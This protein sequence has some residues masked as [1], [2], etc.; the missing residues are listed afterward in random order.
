MIRLGV[1][2]LLVPFLL[3]E[4]ITG[5]FAQQR[6]TLPQEI[7]IEL[8]TLY[9]KWR[10]TTVDS[11]LQREKA[12][13]LSDA[14]MGYVV[15]DFNGDRQT[16]YAVHL[17]ARRDSELQ[18]IVIAFVQTDTGYQHFVL[19]ATDFTGQKFIALVSRGTPV[20][21]D[22]ETGMEN[23]LQHD[24]IEVTYGREAGPLYVFMDGMF[25]DITS[26]E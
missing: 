21:I 15:G 5:V 11:A 2:F 4:V 20:G 13:A 19:E 8:S 14:R 22:T 24:G 16:D 12:D 3:L 26:E 23:I 10:F 6:Q 1:R 17:A 25:V 9:P 7:R 18:D